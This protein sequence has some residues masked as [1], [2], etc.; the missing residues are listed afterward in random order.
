MASS[1][2]KIEFGDREYMTEI[3]GRSANDTH[4][5]RVQ[6]VAVGVVVA[7]P[8]VVAGRDGVADE[9][10]AE[11]AVVTLALVGAGADLAAARLDSTGT[12]QG[13][14]FDPTYFSMVLSRSSALSPIAFSVTLL[15]L[16]AH[17]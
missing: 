16:L 11:P 12:A 5:S 17:S 13:F 15:L 7:V 10:V 2:A 6:V 3:K 1:H 4:Q 8:A 9:A 14:Q